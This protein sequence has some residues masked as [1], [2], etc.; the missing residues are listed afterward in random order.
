M[1]SYEQM[2]EALMDASV[3]LSW[4]SHGH[5]TQGDAQDYLAKVNA[6][7]ALPRLDAIAMWGRRR[8][9][10]SVLRKD[11]MLNRVIE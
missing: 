2:R 5:L 1:N 10:P 6:A 3:A 11:A 8:S 4:A 9:R 7:L